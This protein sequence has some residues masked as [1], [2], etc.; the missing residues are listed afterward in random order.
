MIL[1]E[2]ILEL[3]KQN[4]WSQEELAEKL[5]V[6]RQSVSKW[7][8]AQAVPDL[9]KILLLGELF[10]VSTDYLLKN[11]ME[12]DGKRKDTFQPS[13]KH[14]VTMEEAANLFKDSIESYRNI[15]FGVMLCILS[16]ITLIE[17]AGFSEAGKLSENAAAVIGLVI[18]FLFV[19][20][21]VAIFI[22][23]GLKMGKYKFLETDELYLAY[24]V[25]GLAEKKFED[26]HM[27]FAKKL[28][29]GVVL[30]I[31]AVVPLV[32]T[33]IL[34][35]E[36]ELLTT[37]MVG[38]LLALVSAGVFLIIDGSAIR[39]A[40]NKLLEKE[41]YSRDNKELNKKTEAVMSIYWLFATAIYLGASF[42][43]KRWDITWII[44][45]IAGVLCAIVKICMQVAKKATED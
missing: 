27:N 32:I 4:G 8:S 44:W 15:A 33:A 45:P 1:A 13:N 36:D 11:D 7:E 26:D 14:K 2:K 3:R 38:V 35:N 37:S 39:I 25:K 16:P 19:A 17:L 21:A 9:D 28:T 5:D 42:I 29:S 6:S 10:G 40:C 22:T 18:L 20:G 34:S 31:L 24:D 12:D 41:D 43:T 30:C 23:N